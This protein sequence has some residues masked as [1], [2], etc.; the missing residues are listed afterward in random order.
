MTL[1]IFRRPRSRSPG[2][3]AKENQGDRPR[4]RRGRNVLFNVLEE[5]IDS[6]TKLLQS[7]RARDEER[8][9]EIV[10]R[11]DRMTDS[12]TELAKVTKESMER[13]REQQMDMIKM[14]FEAMIKK[15]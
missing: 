8:Q 4:K 3:S 12:I 13:N 1:V 15:T 11:L 5:R 10:D 9:T 7:A 2:P 6:D 14:M